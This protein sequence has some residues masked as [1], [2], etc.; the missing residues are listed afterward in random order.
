MRAGG[1]RPPTGGGGVVSTGIDDDGSEA[2]RCFELARA[3]YAHHEYRRAAAHWVVGLFHDLAS[4]VG[5]EGFFRAIAAFAER[6]NVTTPAGY[7]PAR[8]LTEDSELN[9]YLL[10]LINWGLHPRDARS[11]VD[12]SAR[13]AAV[14]ADEP[15]RWLASRALHVIQQHAPGEQQLVLD[16]ADVCSRIGAQELAAECVLLARR[17]DPPIP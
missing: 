3:A 10:A 12:C 2:E 14:G 8:K 7:A 11:A 15:A 13:A 17:P 4:M 16:L 6:T 1:N 5:L 9:A